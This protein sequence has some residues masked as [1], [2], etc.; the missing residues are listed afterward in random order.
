MPA[1]RSGR[2]GITSFAT[3]GG[4]GFTSSCRNASNCAFSSAIEAPIA[5]KCLSTIAL[6]L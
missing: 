3:G 5:S 2:S 4:S 1:H 6:T